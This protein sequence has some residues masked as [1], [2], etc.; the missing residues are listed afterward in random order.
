[1]KK[2]KILFKK[3]KISIVL[4]I[5]ILTLILLCVFLFMIIFGQNALYY[6]P[7]PFAAIV[8]I[9]YFLGDKIFKN[10]SLGKKIMKI[11]VEDMKGNSPNIKQIMYRRLLEFINYDLGLFKKS[12]NI[13]KITGTKIVID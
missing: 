6:Y 5:I 4:D 8:F 9:Y 12:Y 13:D 11:H 1:M 7:I 10:R 3:Y 2:D